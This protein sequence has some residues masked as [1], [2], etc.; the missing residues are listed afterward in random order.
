MLRLMLLRHAK[1]SSPSGVLDT[2][3]PLAKRGQDAA[4][5][6]GAYLRGEKL[7]PDLALVSPSLRTRETWSFVQPALGIVK[8]EYDARLYAAHALQLLAVVQEIEPENESLLLV[9]HNPGC[10]ELAGL[11]VGHGAKGTRQHMR[12]KYPT[13][14]LAVIDFDLDAWS[15]IAQ[16]EGTLERFVTPRELG[17]DEDD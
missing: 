6:M 12:Q 17:M 9:C 13:A 4:T 8:V 10:E 1:A 2:D 16:G 3:R 5:R 15:D 14:A 11:L 7:V